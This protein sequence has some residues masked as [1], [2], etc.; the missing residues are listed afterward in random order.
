MKASKDGL[1][2]RF[3]G[4]ALSRALGGTLLSRQRLEG[5][6]EPV[7]RDLD[8]R[9]EEIE[10]LLDEA[11]QNVEQWKADTAKQVAL[12]L[13]SGAAGLIHGLG[14]PLKDELARLEDLL[15]E[16]EADRSQSDGPTGSD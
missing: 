10:N 2:P 8:L 4:E 9:P 1:I 12:A 3:V 14:L 13:T 5:L 16:F 7:V 11:E 15:A 6:V